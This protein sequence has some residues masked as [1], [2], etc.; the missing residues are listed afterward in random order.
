MKNILIYNSG[1]GLGDSIQIMPLILSLK[2]HFR[3]SKIY[4]LGAHKNHFEGNYKVNVSN[5]INEMNLSSKVVHIDYNLIL[6]EN[7]FE[8]NNIYERGDP[9]S[10]LNERAH[11]EYVKSIFKII[12][13]KLN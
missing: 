13:A 6:K 3:R 8:K 7:R 10:H 4:Y 1:G 5:I 11:V 2:N 12:E 9:A